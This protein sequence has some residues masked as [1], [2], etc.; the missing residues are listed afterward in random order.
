ML[1]DAARADR[2]Q[3][4]SMPVK[5]KAPSGRYIFVEATE[6]NFMHLRGSRSIPLIC[7]IRKNAIPTP[8]T[9]YR[10]EQEESIAIA[11]L[12]EDDFSR[13]D[14]ITHISG[15]GGCHFHRP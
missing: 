12:T 2:E 14:P 6:T 5:F 4:E 3:V 15:T 13:S 7:V 10:I 9:V 11:P 1:A 8:K